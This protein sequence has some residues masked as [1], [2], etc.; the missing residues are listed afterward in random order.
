[1]S[2]VRSL[3]VSLLTW[4]ARMVLRRYKPRIIAIT[5]SVGKTSG[6]DAIFAALSDELHVRKSQKSF[7]SE[8]G[9]PLTILGLENAWRNPLRWIW[10]IVRGLWLLLMWHEYPRWLIV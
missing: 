8:I 6:K 7:N 1:M 10:N 3:A 9:V 4:E 2:T 5:G